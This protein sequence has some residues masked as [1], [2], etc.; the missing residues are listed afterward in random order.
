[1]AAMAARKRNRT[2]SSSKWQTRCEAGAQSHGP[3][4]L[5]QRPARSPGCRKDWRTKRETAPMVRAPTTEA[6]GFTLPCEVPCT[7]RRCPRLTLSCP[8]RLTGRDRSQTPCQVLRPFFTLSCADFGPAPEVF[9]AEGMQDGIRYLQDFLSMYPAVQRRIG[10]PDTS[11]SPRLDQ[12]GA[13]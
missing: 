7:Q 11:N 5:L 4:K 8:A 1:M 12:P 9:P 13:L 3:G 6:A 10:Q 2:S